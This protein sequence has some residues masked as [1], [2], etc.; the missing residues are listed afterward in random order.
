MSLWHYISRTW[1]EKGWSRWYSW[2]IRSRLE[3]VKKVARMIMKHLRGILNAVVMDDNNGHAES[4]NSKIKML[5]V[6]SRGLQ[7][8]QWLKTAIYFHSAISYSTRRTLR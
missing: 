5:K 3:P 1:A 4:T 8:M 2:A 6:R 7:N